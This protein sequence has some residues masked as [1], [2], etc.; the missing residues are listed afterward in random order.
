MIS[1]EEANKRLAASSFPRVTR[2]KIEDKISG[3]ENFFSGTLTIS[4]LTMGNGFKVVGTAACAD[5][6]NFDAAIGKRMAFDNAIQQ[7]WAL[8]GYLL[9]E[10]L[11][12]GG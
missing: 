5:P 4:V 8:E 11:A 10:R 12:T 1:N 3:V 6:R 2:E 7:I 9:R